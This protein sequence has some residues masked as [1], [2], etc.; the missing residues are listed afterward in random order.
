MAEFDM[1]D[2]TPAQTWIL[3]SGASSHFCNTIEYFVEYEK[4]KHPIP[5]KVGGSEILHAEGV[6]VTFLEL[7]S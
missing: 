5:V 2:D 7:N 3:D 6:G 4:L 1:P